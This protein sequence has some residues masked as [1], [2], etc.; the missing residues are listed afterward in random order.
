ML[1]EP[2]G[3]P[4]EFRYEPLR[5]FIRPASRGATVINCC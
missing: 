2:Y 5:L 4:V 3:I 1:T